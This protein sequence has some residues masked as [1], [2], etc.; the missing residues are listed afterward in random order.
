[1][2][3]DESHGIE[4]PGYLVQCRSVEQLFTRDVQIHI[5]SCAFNPVDVGYPNEARRS[6]ALHHQAIKIAAGLG[7]RG[8][9]AHD[10]AAK[11]PEAELIVASL[12]A[13]QRSF[14]AFI[15][16]RL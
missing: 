4:T 15:T 2:N 13:G 11:F 16:E 1:M 6:P 10:A 3:A 9:H 14:P 8:Q 12:G 7:A 5:N